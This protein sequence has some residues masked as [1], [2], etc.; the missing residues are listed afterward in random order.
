M[1]IWDVYFKVCKVDNMSVSI[2]KFSFYT[3]VNPCNQ[4]KTSHKAE[5]FTGKTGRYQ[6]VGI[7]K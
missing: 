5:Y 1:T 6:N 3:D 4:K 2:N 7:A